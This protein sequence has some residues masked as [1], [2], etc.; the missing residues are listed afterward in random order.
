MRF[1]D[2]FSS[3]HDRLRAMRVPL[4]DAYQSFMLPADHRA[5]LRRL[6]HRRETTPSAILREAV[7]IILA[8]DV[9]TPDERS[10]NVFIRAAERRRRAA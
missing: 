8:E 6:A 3:V 9:E 7:E 5:A 1:G 4:Y 10:E 2:W